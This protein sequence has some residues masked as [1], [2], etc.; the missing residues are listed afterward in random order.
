MPRT[1]EERTTMIAVG[2]ILR[3]ALERLRESQGG[4]VKAGHT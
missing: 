2:K 1:A 4:K 3:R